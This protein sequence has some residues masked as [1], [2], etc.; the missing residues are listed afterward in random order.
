M[1]EAA[2][3]GEPHGSAEVVSCADGAD[4]VLFAGGG[5]GA[6]QVSASGAGADGGGDHDDADGAGLSGGGVPHG[7]SA[8]DG[9]AGS[10]AAGLVQRSEPGAGCAGVPH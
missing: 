3:A 7:S 4:Q 5:V 6:T 9:E 8:G 1:R 10:G 2:P